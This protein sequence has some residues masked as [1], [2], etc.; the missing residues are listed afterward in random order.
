[1]ITLTATIEA[2]NAIINLNRNNVLSLNRSIVDRSD[3][4]LPNWGIISN[5]G[6]ATFVDKTGEI[7]ELINSA[8]VNN[9][10][11]HFALTNTLVNGAEENVGEFY[12]ADWD[13]DNDSREV[14]VSLQ[15]D[16]EEWQDI[17]INGISYDPYA[18]KNVTM[19]WV[20]DYLHSITPEKYNMLSF[21]NL[22][23]E[24]QSVL[25]NAHIEYIIINAKNLWSA[26]DLLCQ[27]CQL[28]I[29]KDNDGITVCRYNGGN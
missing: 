12:T 2:E 23:T 24:T 5:A 9:A 7:L 16:L 29:Y 11:C 18:Q 22:D 4:S 1:M 20:Y 13:Y 17:L 14:S 10:K 28:H 15:D 27:A 25:Q 6:T 3:F 19:Q 21:E 8:K 26:W